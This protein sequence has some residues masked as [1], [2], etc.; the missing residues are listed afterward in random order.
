MIE[1]TFIGDI[2][3][4]DELF[5]KGYGIKSKTDESHIAIWTKNIRDV[6]NDTNYII[7]NLESPL[8]DDKDARGATFYGRPS[9]AEVLKNSGINVLNVAN[10]H[11]MEHGVEGFI[12]TLE[13]LH[14]KRLST[15]GEIEDGNP[16]ILTI[17]DEEIMICITGFCDERVCS[18]KNPS[19]YSSLDEK[20]IFDTLERMKAL[21]PDVMIFVF[22]WGNEYIH[23]PSLEQRQ[24]AHKLID[25][26]VHL[27]IGH[28]PHV[29]QP[30]EQYKNGH[31]IYSLGNFCF[32]DVQSDHFSKGMIARVTIQEQEIKKISFEGVIV[33]DQAYTDDLVRSMDSREFDNYFSQINQKYNRMKLLPDN[34]YQS[35][36]Q[37]LHHHLHAKER[38]LMRLSLIKKMFSLSHQYKMQLFKNIKNH[39]VP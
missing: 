1:L 21:H 38:I 35:N 31:I 37:K 7:G 36:Y 16:K 28:H 6:V 27:I 12:H 8:V 17:Q 26:G 10:N 9:F 34:L 13:T 4:G 14:A 3:P 5:T 2:F 15:F 33:Q 32:D 19:C 39:L 18:K 30:Y 20:Q 25:G 22:H 23:L 29:I 24:L 11:I